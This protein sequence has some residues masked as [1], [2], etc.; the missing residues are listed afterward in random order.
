MKVLA[1]QQ[2]QNIFFNLKKN[3]KNTLGAKSIYSFPR[4]VCDFNPNQYGLFYAPCCMAPSV[5]FD[6]Q[7]QETV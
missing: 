3:L 5:Q 4:K 2:T 7:F 1:C 6:P